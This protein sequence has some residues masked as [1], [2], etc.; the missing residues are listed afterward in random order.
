MVADM[1]MNF[2]KVGIM[3]SIIFSVVI[4][5]SCNEFLKSI[6]WEDMA[7]TGL[8]ERHEDSGKGTMTQKYNCYVI[9][10]DDGKKYAPTNL[11]D[12]FIVI[13]LRVEFRGMALNTSNQNEI[14]E[15]ELSYIK[16]IS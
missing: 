5:N 4:I 11:S 14:Y 7:T 3:I 9:I 15:M 1:I 2:R 13:N 12:E 16:G 6:D 8:N 10:C